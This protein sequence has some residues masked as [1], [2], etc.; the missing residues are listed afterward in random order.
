M[1][2]QSYHMVHPGNSEQVCKHPRRDGSTVALLFGLAGI[3]EVPRQCQHVDSQTRQ[4]SYGITASKSISLLILTPK[5]VAHTC[6][7]LC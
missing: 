4:A 5:R 3:W 2:I 1:Q 7:G 6:D